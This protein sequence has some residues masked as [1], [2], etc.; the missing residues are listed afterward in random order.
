MLL[1]EHGRWLTSSSSADASLRVSGSV[2]DFSAS[3]F[4]FFFFLGSS[5]GM[6]ATGSST[7]IVCQME[8]AYFKIEKFGTPI[9]F[10]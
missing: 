8:D 5:D 9:T 7:G 2:D 3:P 4:S 10:A 1:V 6:G